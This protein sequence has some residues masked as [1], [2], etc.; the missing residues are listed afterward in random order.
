MNR[1][2][3]G[4]WRYAIVVGAS[5]GMGEAIARRLAHSGT[6]VALLARRAENLERITREI[7]Q[8][9]GEERA[10]PFVHDVRN[11]SG[12]ERT[13][14]QIVARLGGLDLVVYAAGIQP[15]IGPQEFSTEK[16]LETVQTNLA[17]AVAWLD[18]AAM[19]FMR[20]RDGTI[21]GISSV[22]GDRGR[23]P[24]PVYG[25][26]KAA[27]NAFLESLYN[28]L[29]TAGVTVTTV[30]A[31]YVQTATLEAVGA[32]GPIPVISADVAAG[33]ILAAAAA[34]RR[35]AYV[36]PWWRYVMLVIRAIPAFI[37]RWFPV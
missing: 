1:G 29:S 37:F 31:G 35:V 3:T 13:F 7:N 32:Q 26:T 9:C 28:R 12:V 2:P 36:P 30:K 24:F 16:D 21:V 20:A 27:L 33:Q 10:V 25:A 15:P 34:G 14:Q 11:T 18:Q 8:A 4:R 5:S 22:A 17:G 6:R 23:R 19:R